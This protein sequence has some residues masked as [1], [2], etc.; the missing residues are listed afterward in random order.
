MRSAASRVS[1]ING[2][3][4]SFLS[5]SFDF[6][7]PGFTKLSFIECA[8]HS[9]LSDSARLINAAFDEPYA[10]AFG[11]PLN[12][13]TDDTIATC[14]RLSLENSFSA[15]SRQRTTPRKLTS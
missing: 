8:L 7:K 9:G 12:P 5:V 13:D 2:M 6:T 3:V 1:K 11:K 14:P 10:A 15:G 4:K